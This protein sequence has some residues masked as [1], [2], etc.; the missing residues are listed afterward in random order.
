MIVLVCGGRGYGGTKEEQAHIYSTLNGIHVDTPIEKI[1]EGGAT[2]ADTWA[3]EWAM[4]SSIQVKVYPANWNKYGKSAGHR[5]N[6]EML[7]YEDVDLVVAF[8]G[9]AGTASMVHMA[10]NKG[11]EV[12]R[13]DDLSINQ[14]QVVL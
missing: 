2:G 4:D 1:I 9:G 3:Y 13:C 11:I 6:A 7:K 14:N 8:P 10:L 5:R 12:K